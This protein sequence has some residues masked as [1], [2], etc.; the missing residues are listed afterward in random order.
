MQLDIHSDT[1]YLSVA[2]AK[3][4]ASGV[5]F[6]S[7]GL[8]DSDNPEC[9]VPITNG[10][11]LVVFKIMRNI[12]ASA[13]EAEYGAIFVNAQTAVPIR[14]TISEMGRKQGPMAIQVDNFTAVGI[15][16]N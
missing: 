7:K 16:T 9:F 6:L 1:S 15:T 5:L 8:P 10:I 3:S 11:L 2:Q 12:M 14:T 13:A 4:R